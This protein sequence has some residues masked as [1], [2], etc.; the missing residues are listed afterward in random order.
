MSLVQK[1]KDIVDAAVGVDFSTHDDAEIM[2]WG[3]SPSGYYFEQYIDKTDIL[4]SQGAD[5]VAA[6]A[7]LTSIRNTAETD[8]L[9]KEMLPYLEGTA[10]RVEGGEVVGGVN[11]GSPNVQGW[12][13]LLGADPAHVLT[14]SQAETLIALATRPVSNWQL[15]QVNPKVE[16][17]AGA[18]GF[19]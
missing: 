17:V 4:Q 10:N 14:S 15:Y 19:A 1:I 8:V 6:F 11:I 13:V 2:T 18:R 7:L 5:L 3:N 9:M 16:H 12:L